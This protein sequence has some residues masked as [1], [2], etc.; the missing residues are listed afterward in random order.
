MSDPNKKKKRTYQWFFMIA[1]VLVLAFLGA[2]GVGFQNYSALYEVLFISLH[3][4][5]LGSFVIAL[6][7]AGICSTLVNFCLNGDLLYGFYQRMMKKPFPALSE[8]GKVKYW[9]GVGVFIV[10]GLLFGFMAF[11]VVTAGGLAALDW[12]G[13]VS[14]V[15]GVFVSVITIVQELETWLE[16]FDNPIAIEI[17][18]KWQK[19]EQ[20]KKDELKVDKVIES[21]S[22]RLDTFGEKTHEPLD[23][24]PLENKRNEI[25]GKLEKLKGQ[26]K[27]QVIAQLKA[28]QTEAEYFAIQ[29]SWRNVLKNKWEQF[30]KNRIGYAAGFITSV[31]NVMGL[32]LLFTIGLAPVLIQLGVAALPA[33]I[34]GFSLAFTAGA[35]T[36]FYFYQGFLTD[37]CSR[38]TE[39][40]KKLLN[41]PAWGAGISAAL[42]NGAVNAVLAYFGVTLILGPLLESIGVV[43]PSLL[44]LGIISAIFVG[45]ASIILGTNFYIVFTRKVAG[46]LGFEINDDEKKTV[47]DG[48]DMERK[49]LINAEKKAAEVQDGSFVA[50]S[51]QPQP[52]PKNVVP[53]N[54]WKP[55]D[56][57]F[58]V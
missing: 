18:K 28:F 8:G 3:L 4:S 27:D 34:V 32:S 48:N 43:I 23:H 9:L 45:L 37:F 46:W 49:G 52:P 57:A 47:G 16:G 21:L 54:Q 6:V 17:Y 40:W 44:T 25:I 36:E 22:E 20:D 33:I 35:F 50:Q 19:L 58:Q 56:V 12:V 42:I 11:S 29:P 30:K 14:I 2:A 39:R 15:A 31:L 53:A 7:A 26:K 55:C 41:S 24:A 51:T 5:P 38:V 10:T 13:I 1:V